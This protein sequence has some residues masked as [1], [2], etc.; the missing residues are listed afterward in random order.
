M[1]Y[2]TE[3]NLS[4]G[5]RMRQIRQAAH[6]TQEQLADTLGVTVNYLGEIERGRRPLSLALAS[7]FCQYFHVTYDY[8]YRGNK[9]RNGD[10]IR[11]NVVY[12][13]AHTLVQEHIRSCS[14][15]EI[16]VISHLIGSYLDVS[17]QFKHQH[18]PNDHNCCQENTA[19]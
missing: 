2:T 11:E 8:L 4:I 18:I 12:E 9:S 1:D 17:R 14:P 16:V 13:T 5:Q 15:E 19:P 10:W 7:Q 6:M 3:N